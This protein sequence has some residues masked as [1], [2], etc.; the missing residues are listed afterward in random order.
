MN[1]WA[2]K[3]KAPVIPT[4]QRKDNA[5]LSLVRLL[6]ITNTIIII[7]T[8]IHNLPRQLISDLPQMFP[9]SPLYFF[10]VGTEIKT[11]S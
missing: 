11:Y 9:L 7:N 6:S 4:A 10:G 3:L 2:I 1:I 8:F 5:S